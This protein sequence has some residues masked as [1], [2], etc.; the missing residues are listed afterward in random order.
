MWSKVGEWSVFSLMCYIAGP[1]QWPGAAVRDRGRCDGAA[2]ELSWSPVPA[3]EVVLAAQAD[4]SPIIHG[5]GEAASA[6]CVPWFCESFVLPQRG[7]TWTICPPTFRT[8]GWSIH[9]PESD[10]RH[11]RFLFG[12]RIRWRTSRDRR[13]G[14]FAASLSCHVCPSHPSEL[15]QSSE[16]QNRQ[17]KCCHFS[18]CCEWLGGGTPEQRD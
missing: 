17:W 5:I 3:D 9:T 4:D 1:L 10:T 13:G 7:G 2:R 12:R 18:N 8:D 11:W 14:L 15:P 6:G 16:Q